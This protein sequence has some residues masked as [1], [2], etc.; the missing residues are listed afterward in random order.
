MSNDILKGFTRVST[1]LSVLPT[2]TSETEDNQKTWGFPFQNINQEVLR[3][4]CIIGTNVHQA[5]NAWAINDFSPLTECEKGYFES[6]LRWNEIVKLKPIE[7]E[8][9]LYDDSLKIT[10]AIDMLGKIEGTDSLIL[11]DFKTSAN[12]DDKKW[13]LQAA[14]YHHLLT[15]NKFSINQSVLFIQLD[16][17]GALPKCHTFSIDSKLKNLMISTYNIYKYLTER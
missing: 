16:K 10:G 5:I 12:A 6:F 7:S 2:V 8:L 17:T 15:V 9:R 13:P 14:F 11:V 1:I 3:K 4:K